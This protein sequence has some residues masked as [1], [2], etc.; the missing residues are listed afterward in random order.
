MK[1]TIK[2]KR[3]RLS[4][5]RRRVRGKASGTGDRPR[6]CVV[7]TMKHM[8]A[9]IIDD[10][11]GTTL[12]AASTLSPEVRKQAPRTWNREAA[13]AVGKLIAERAKA[14]GVSTVLFDRA[15]RKF[16]GR[17]K[18]LADAAREGGLVF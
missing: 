10:L 17:V 16:H 6:L 7:R 4:R 3:E 13:Q 15:G 2:A 11:T 5:R 9:Q 1:E 8:Y 12:A 18:A 14:K